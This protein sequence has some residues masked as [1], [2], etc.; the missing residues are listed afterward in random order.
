V[1]TV[2][3]DFYG[4]VSEQDFVDN[5][6]I[7]LCVFTL[8][9]LADETMYPLMK[10]AYLNSTQVNRKRKYCWEQIGNAS[11]NRSPCAIPPHYI[12]STRTHVAN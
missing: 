12:S 3:N 10:Q 1:S 8:E 5:G 9:V 2:S 6:E 4:D 11:Y 7:D